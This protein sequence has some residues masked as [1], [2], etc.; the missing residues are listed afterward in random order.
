MYLAKITNTI[1]KW[2]KNIYC[3]KMSVFQE[4]ICPENTNAYD[5]VDNIKIEYINSIV[6]Q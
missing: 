3:L 5:T 2:Y 6:L 4:C 1:S